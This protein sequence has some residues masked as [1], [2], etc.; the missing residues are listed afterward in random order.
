MPVVV[1]GLWAGFGAHRVLR[2]LDLE[3]DVGEVLALVGVNGTGKSTLLRCLAGLHRCDEGEVSVLGG[4]PS[5]DPRFW[6]AVGYSADE[7][8]WYPGLTV[9]EHLELVRLAHEPLP[10]SWP[11]VGELLDAFGLAGEADATPL[12]LSTGQRRRLSLLTVLVRPSALLL[13]DEPEQGLDP[14]FRVR[15]GERLRS[16]AD[17]GRTVVMASHDPVLL[18]A[19][20]ARQVRV[21]EGRA[22]PVP[23]P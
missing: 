22:V 19:S 2:G 6:R 23:G 1:R 11:S 5:D 18:A 3:A 8:P 21:D 14:D 12:V 10:S 4:P 17:G 13:L 16:Y 9:R 20:G 7:P 15:L